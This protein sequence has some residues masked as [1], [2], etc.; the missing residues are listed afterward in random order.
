MLGTSIEQ[1]Q[2]LLAFQERASC[3]EF[4]WLVGGFFACLFIFTSSC[5]SLIYWSPL[6]FLV[7]VQFS[8]LKLNCEPFGTRLCLTEWCAAKPVPCF[9]ESSAA[10]LIRGC[11]VFEKTLT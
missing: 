2:I 4:A 9:C 5:F 3:V 1:K 6:V 7:A 11:A 8:C 10:V